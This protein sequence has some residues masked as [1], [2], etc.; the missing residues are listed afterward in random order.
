LRQHLIDTQAN[1]V[2][3]GALFDHFSHLA[4]Q[5]RGTGEQGFT[6]DHPH[7]EG[8]RHPGVGAHFLVLLENRERGLGG[9]IKNQAALTG[10]GN[11]EHQVIIDDQLLQK[12]R[13]NL[14]HGIRNGFR[15]DAFRIQ[16]L[17]VEP[18]RG[19]RVALVDQQLVAQANGDG[20]NLYIIFF[21]I[22]FR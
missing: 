22:G 5:Y 14:I 3:V 10:Y 4:N 13:L 21:E 19:L 6:V 11:A 18:P 12:H 15:V 1:G 8:P 20:K 17:L 7:R 2:S 9:V 16:L